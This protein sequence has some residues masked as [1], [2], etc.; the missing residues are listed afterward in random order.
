MYYKEYGNTGI[1]VSAIGFGA[2][3]YDE[4]DVK[5]ERFAACAEIPLYAFEHGINY[6]DT[7][8]W[9]CDDKS[10][11]ITGIAVS[12]VPRDRI[13]LSSKQNFGTVFGDPTRD[14]FFKR[15]EL[16]L[17]RLQTD[18]IDFY[19]LW[20]LLDLQAYEKGMEQ[21]YR[22][23]EE[24]KSQGMIRNIVFSSHMQGNDIETVIESGKF[25]GML[26]G[27]NA[28]NYQFRQ[29]GLE[30]AYSNG[31]GVVA[32]NPLGG[33]V[34]PQNPEIFK[35]LTEGTDLNVAEA[36]LRFVASHKEVTIT[37]NGCTT[38]DQVDQAVR[39]VQ[40]LEEKPAKEI[41]AHYANL[42]TALN[43]LCTGCGYC[44]A[45]PVHIPI[46]KLMDAY[47]HKIFSGEIKSAYQRCDWHWGIKPALAADCISCGY[48][49]KECTQHLNIIERL[50]EI[51]D[52]IE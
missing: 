4:E 37:L 31:M 3:R 43:D 47:N 41:V 5:A 39:A 12:Q 21:L 29:S 8:P 30:K 9:Y 34:I 48:C 38:K 50:K 16:S 1:Q 18:Y 51:A 26:I 28:L 22:Y 33:G 11:E 36:A 45:C 15:L 46:P 35:Y 13:Y 27:Y 6:W 52:G 24:A 20:C 44:D 25:R 7:A 23:F 32:M 42:G 40:G 49:E 2:M 19:H 10:E 17:K 14:N